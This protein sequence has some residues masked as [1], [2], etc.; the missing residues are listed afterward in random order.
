[1]VYDEELH[2][3]LKTTGLQA[4]DLIKPKVKKKDPRDRS[5]TSTVTQPNRQATPLKAS[6]AVAAN[7]GSGLTVAGQQL[8]QT[9]MG[10]QSP[11]AGANNQSVQQV[12]MITICKHSYK[13]HVWSQLITSYNNLL[14]ASQQW[15][16]YKY[17]NFNVYIHKFE[18]VNQI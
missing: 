15:I 11:A 6:T 5:H 10:L 17:Y 9:L 7:G 16:L 13:F 2:V 12:W 14:K 4:S 18:I 1:M 8:V 3:Y